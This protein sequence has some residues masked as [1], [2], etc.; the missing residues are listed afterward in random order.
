MS[1]IGRTGKLSQ[2]AYVKVDFLAEAG[3]TSKTGL[4]YVAGYVEVHL[5]GFLLTDGIDYTATNGNSVD[6]IVDLVLNDEITITALKTF[7]VADTY[8]QSQADTLL[9]AKLDA[10]GPLPAIDGSALTGVGKVLQV[11]H[12]QA[13][14][15][16]TNATTSYVDTGVT[17]TITPS[18]T[19]SKVLVIHATQ[20][21]VP[22][23]P[24]QVELNLVRG[25]TVV[26]HSGYLAYSN[27]TGGTMDTLT[28]TLLDSPATSSAITY[29]VEF[30][31]R[32]G[33]AVHAQYD[34]GGGDCISTITLMEIAQ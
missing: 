9:A 19:A 25:S 21:Y 6:F 22:T 11:L 31:D 8:S 2:R 24:K 20:F 29:K 27:A 28:H 15:Q 16:V 10:A 17:L 4:S 30:R 33:A 1:Y 14:T 7:A 26:Q 3:Q 34:D 18:S 12:F 23:T 32:T 5:N 13:S